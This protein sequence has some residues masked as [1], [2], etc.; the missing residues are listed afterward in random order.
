MKTAK[1]KT[2]KKTAAR[3][4]KVAR[5]RG[6]SFPSSA[7]GQPGYGDPIN[8]KSIAASESEAAVAVARAWLAKAGFHEDPSGESAERIE[9]RGPGWD[10]ESCEHYVDVRVYVPALD[11]EHVVD[12]THPDGITAEAA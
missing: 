8:K 11:V 3:G 5:T 12:G 1:K 6:K 7:P 9:I 10:G 2:A 4:T